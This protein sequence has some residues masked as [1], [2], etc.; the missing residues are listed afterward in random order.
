MKK[1]RAAPVPPPLTDGDLLKRWEDT[2]QA[3]LSVWSSFT[4]LRAPTFF[5]EDAE[6][7]ADGMAGE[8]A[9]IRLVDQTVMVNLNTIRGLG[10]E[11]K[12][13]EVLAHEI[14][15]HVFVPANMTDSARMFV[16]FKR[17]YSTLP[18]NVSHMLG[19]LYGDL[20]INYRLQPSPPR[21]GL[22]IAGVYRKLKESAERKKDASGK[23]APASDVWKVYTRTYEFLW[24]LRKE[25]LAPEGLGDDYDGD[26]RL[27]SEL[28][29][30]FSGDWLKGVK[31]FAY[32]MYKYVY[33]D[34]DAKRQQTFV[35][36]GLSDTERACGCAGG[37]V[38]GAVPDGLTAKS[39]GELSDDDGFDDLISGMGDDEDDGPDST[40]RSKRKVPEPPN[41]AP[42]KEGIGSRGQFREPF[43]YAELLKGLGLNLK[44]HEITTRYYRERALP[45]LIPF[46]QQRAPHTMEPLAEGTESWD[47]GDAL[48][49]LDVMSSVLRSPVLIPGVTTQQRVYGLTPGNDP[50]RVPVDLDIYVDCSGSM[51][52][53]ATTISYLALAAAILALSAL[54]AGARVQATLWSG[55]GQFE[56]SGGFIRD[57][58]RTL[59]IVTGYIAGGTAFPLNVL[60]ETYRNRKPGD[61]PAHIVIISD[62]GVDTILN[63]DEKGTLGAKICAEALAAARGGATMVLNI[64]YNNW[65]AEA[66]LSKL[67]FQINRVTNWEQ[68][69]SFAREFARK[70]YEI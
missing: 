36:L 54:R 58:A 8:I 18:A 64:S 25:T 57:E 68:L 49:N 70:T 67:G 21:D 30:H 32:I 42:T 6:A 37:D 4:M 43:E 56:T 20:M 31:R 24:K 17:V 33:Q 69:V 5:R 63:K 7:K 12:A 3:A 44:A 10:I 23:I 53:P 62:D 47:A 39:D 50:A 9:A 60:R 40:G 16:I 2:W 26:A 55:A 28:I 61:P 38:L 22:D 34:E 1:T 41:T 52:H 27:I 66:P 45:Y 51:P 19:N 48:D 14:G 46:P 59:G 13:L 65:K 35:R 15:H 11:D 29:K